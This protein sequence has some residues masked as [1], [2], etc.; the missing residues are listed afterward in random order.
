MLITFF[1][2]VNIVIHVKIVSL[3][4]YI[5]EVLGHNLYG[6]TI[7]DS[8]VVVGFMRLVA[9]HLN[10]LTKGE[11]DDRSAFLL[12]SNHK[13]FLGEVV[14]V[15]ASCCGYE[16]LQLEAFVVHHLIHQLLQSLDVD[17]IGVCL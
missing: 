1:P 10:V 16:V 12:Q 15:Y 5:V 3:T 4:G 6:N 17:G 11:H 8:V 9:K 13:V 2:Y 14:S 7:E